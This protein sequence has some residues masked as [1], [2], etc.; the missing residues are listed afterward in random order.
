MPENNDGLIFF[1][2]FDNGTPYLLSWLFGCNHSPN[3]LSNMSPP[4]SN[5]SFS[6]FPP[7][8][9]IP[10]FFVC[11]A[12]RIP[13]FST[14]LFRPNVNLSR[15]CI[16]NG[17]GLRFF[18]KYNDSIPREK[19]KVQQ[20]KPACLTVHHHPLLT[21]GGGCHPFIYQPPSYLPTE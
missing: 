21:N 4:P 16:V 11:L 7:S 3:S 12:F 2:F 10:I 17:K 5:M 6:G 20:K 13:N 15:H 9:L 19:N 1:F 14:H 8:S 18:S